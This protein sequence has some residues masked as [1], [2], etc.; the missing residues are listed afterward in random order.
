MEDL[1]QATDT[2]LE[3]LHYLNRLRLSGTTNMFVAVP[4]VEAELGVTRQEAAR[5]LALW[6]ENF[7]ED[8]NYEMLRS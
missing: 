8:G 7:N 1:R 2:E 4:Y 6:M 5:L 3:A